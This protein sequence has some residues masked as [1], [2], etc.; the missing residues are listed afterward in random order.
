MGSLNF[1]PRL[2]KGFSWGSHKIESW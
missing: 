1:V 2:V